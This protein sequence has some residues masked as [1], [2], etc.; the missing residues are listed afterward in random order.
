MYHKRLLSLLLLLHLSIVC[1]WAVGTSGMYQWSVQLRGYISPETGKEPQAFLWVPQGCQTVQAVVFAQQNMTEEMIFKYPHF[2]QQMQQM[3]VALLWVAP[4]F[5]NTWDPADG[6]Q[7]VFDEMITAIAFQSG[8][9][10]IAQAP[11]IPLGHSAQATF[12]WNFAAWNPGRTLCVI[13]FHGDAPRTNLCGYGTANVEWGRTRN[14]DGIP[15][16]MVMGEYEWW[17]ARLLPA[18]AFQMMYPESC[19]SFL[20]DTE[21]GHFECMPETASYIALFIRKALEQRGPSLKPL[22]RADGWLAKSWSP[23]DDARPEAAPVA[24]Y[25][26]DRHEAFW[27]FDREMA[28]LT[29]QRY[30]A[31]QGKREQSIGFVYRGQSVALDPKRHGGMVIDFVPEATDPLLLDVTPVFTSAQHAAGEPHVEV[32]SGPAYKAADGTI[33]LQP[34]ECGMDNHRRSFTVWLVA[35]GEGDATYKRC[36]QPIEVRLPAS[37]LSHLQ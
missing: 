35:I 14:I 17:E 29:E 34:Y 10:E 31:T 28:Q 21:S 30:H 6:C 4:A 15:A 16:L 11:I 26:G 13:S 19:I 23:D 3:G 25:K 37:I 7:K 8:H 24:S 36:V 20:C 9:P 18:L 27:Y 1:A 33:R 32:I 5:T 22:R 12:P 2:Q